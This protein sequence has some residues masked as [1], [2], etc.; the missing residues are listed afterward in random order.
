MAAADAIAPNPTIPT[1]MTATSIGSFH[2][3]SSGSVKAD[4]QWF[5]D[6]QFAER[7]VR[8]M[9]RVSASAMVKK[10]FIAPSRCTPKVSLYLQAFIRPRKQ[11]A[12]RPQLVF[13]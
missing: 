8:P 4:G 11:E 7:Q 13:G 1:P 2:S 10:F 9:S 3:S 5:D 12:Q 6:A